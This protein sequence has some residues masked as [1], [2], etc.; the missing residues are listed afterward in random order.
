MTADVIVVAID[1]SPLGSAVLPYAETIARLTQRQIRLLTVLKRTP[2]GH[3]VAAASLLL[4][5]EREEYQRLQ[6]NLNTTVA[7]VRA[8]GVVASALL[9]RGDPADEI[10]TQAEKPEVSLI[11]LSTAGRGGLDRWALGSVADKVMRLSSKPT[12]IVRRAYTPFPSAPVM[13]H[14]VLVPLD[15]SALAEQ[16]VPLAKPFL[17]GGATLWLVRVVPL[18]IEDSAPYGGL[19]ELAELEE[20]SVQEAE[21]YLASVRKLL[22]PE[23]AVETRVLRGRPAENLMG[24]ALHEHIDLVV[25]ATHGAGGV[26][27]LVVGS[28]ADFLIRSSVPTLLVRPDAIREGTAG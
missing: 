26:R 13:V 6:A 25:M 10:L 5:R 27:R 1:G 11:A 3:S 9:A 15:G 28:T 4:Q 2:Q 16:A 19:P 24:F 20:Q 17:E 8:H 14:A 22:S 18:L 23:D 12:L 7:T 21:V